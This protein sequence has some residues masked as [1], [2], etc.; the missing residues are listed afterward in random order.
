MFESLKGCTVIPLFDL[1]FIL[2][3]LVVLLS[4]YVI[5]NEK[6]CSRN[7]LNVS[8]DYPWKAGI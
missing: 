1:A 3:L 2:A 4:D 8:F 6:Q 5:L 7:T